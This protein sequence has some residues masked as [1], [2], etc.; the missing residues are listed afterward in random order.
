MDVIALLTEQDITDLELTKGQ[1]LLRKCLIH[2]KIL[3]LL[4]LLGVHACVI[5]GDFCYYIFH[6][7][8]QMK[9]L[10]S[11]IYIHLSWK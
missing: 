10:S 11:H 1:T 5:L 3:K 2:T 8:Y 6:L 7:I 9:L 4:T